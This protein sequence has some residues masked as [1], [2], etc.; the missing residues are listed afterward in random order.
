MVFSVWVDRLL[1]KAGPNTNAS[2]IFLEV[3]SLNLRWATDYPD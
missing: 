2:D 1:E 3:P